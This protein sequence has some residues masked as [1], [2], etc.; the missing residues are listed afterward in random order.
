VPGRQKERCQKQAEDKDVGR[1]ATS[2]ARDESCEMGTTRS[3]G[4]TRPDSH[5]K[6]LLCTLGRKWTII[7][8]PEEKL[9]QA[10]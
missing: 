7:H 4:Q 8:G 2:Q 6:G 9:R 3:T 10:W 5:V 1:V